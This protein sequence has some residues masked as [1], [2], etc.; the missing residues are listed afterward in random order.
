[1]WE[2]LVNPSGL[3]PEERR[4]ESCHPDVNIAEFELRSENKYFH[5]NQRLWYFGAKYRVDWHAPGVHIPLTEGEITGFNGTGVAIVHAVS[6]KTNRPLQSKKLSWHRIS[7]VRGG[8]APA[9][10]IQIFDDKDEAIE[11]YRVYLAGKTTELNLIMADKTA[12]YLKWL[13]ELE[14]PLR[15]VDE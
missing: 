14:A 1:M 8:F 2:S 12:K 4:F 3:G 5:L 6:P 15:E 11:A 7:N 13:D 9:R 10:E